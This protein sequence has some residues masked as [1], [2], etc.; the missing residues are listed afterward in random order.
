MRQDILSALNER[1]LVADGAMGSEL[2]ARGVDPATCC[3]AALLHAPDLVAAI[4]DDYLAAGAEIIETNSF[5]ANRRKLARFGLDGR[6]AELNRLAADLAK[7]RAGDRAYVAGSMGPLGRL[8]QDRPDDA[9]IRDIYR[10]QA[11]ALLEGGADLLILETFSELP[12]LLCALEGVRGLTDLPVVAQMVFSLGLSGVGGQASSPGE[13]LR[14]LREHGADVTG[15]N[16]GLGPRGLR[17]ILS[18]LDP[19]LGPYSVFPNAGFPQKLDDRTVYASTPEYF[20]ENLLACLP[21]G[22]RMLG[23]CCGT[24]PAHI[25]ALRAALDAATAKPEAARPEDRGARPEKPARRGPKAGSFAAKVADK[26]RVF[27]VE[28]DPP[29]H[30]DVSQVLAAAAELHQAGVDAI[31]MAENPLA[32]PRLS[33]IALA[34]RVRRETG[35]EVVVHLTGRDRNLIGLQST[36][37]GLSCLGLSNVLAVTG[38]PP[39]SGG[40]ERLTG[41]FDVGSMELIPLLDGFNKGRNAAGADMRGQT[42]FCIGAAFNPNTKDIR[43]QVRRLERKAALGAAYALT[44]P[45]Y[46]RDKVDAVAMATGHLDIPVYL[47]IMPLASFRNAE[48]LHNEFPG[49]RIPDEV[50]ERMRLAGDAGGAEGVEI[51]WELMAY[52]LPK[53]AGIYIMPPFNR[54]ATALELLRRARSLSA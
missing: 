14:I 5:G 10:E 30:L 46:S 28:L 33:N 7:R 36:I 43:L 35:A 21:F 16:C 45:V 44:Q 23:G 54:H 42:D 13:C 53:V 8:Q 18:R 12:L 32:S 37:M 2:F 11:E 40:E 25:R 17:E 49:I 52:A 1:P 29:K 9:R 3:E 27:L 15:V 34:S 4:H 47:G 31:T 50:R 6:V 41:V 24:G 19:D 48:F 20:A 26:R 39:P 22:A 38:D 51:A